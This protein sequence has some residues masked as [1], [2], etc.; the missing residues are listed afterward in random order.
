MFLQ[1]TVFCM[2]VPRG[3]FA[4]CVLVFVRSWVRG[5]CGNGTSDILFQ[6]ALEV[7]STVC[8]GGKTRFFF[9]HTLLTCF[10]T[11]HFISCIFLSSVRSLF[12]T[13]AF[14]CLCVAWSFGHSFFFLS[15]FSVC[16]VSSPIYF[17]GIVHWGGF[18]LIR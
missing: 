13:L 14:L 5:E 7:P 15:F 6:E 1:V 17:P 12:V 18:I 10:L 16:S 11:F 8:R 9:L 3:L 4:I 2:K